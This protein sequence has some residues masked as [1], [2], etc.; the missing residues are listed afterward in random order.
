MDKELQNKRDRDERMIPNKYQMRYLMDYTNSL[1]DGIH[2]VNMMWDLVD[3]DRFTAED[4]QK[5]IEYQVENIADAIDEL[6]SRLDLDRSQFVTHRYDEVDFY[7]KPMKL[8]NFKKIYQE[9]GEFVHKVAIHE[10]FA[11]NNDELDTMIELLM[12]PKG[13]QGTFKNTT[14]KVLMV[15]E[16]HLIFEVKASD[17]IVFDDNEVPLEE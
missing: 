8:V 10:D 5:I 2:R 4:A 11:F 12:L 1:A 6:I 15:L 17:F 14:R 13:V 16:N 3:A 7:K 9:K